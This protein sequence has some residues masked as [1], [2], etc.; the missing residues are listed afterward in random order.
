M[1]VTLLWR[2]DVHL[3]DH[4]PRSRKDDWTAT[5][6]SKLAQIG[7]LARTH[8]AAAVL[9]GGDFF[10]LK[11]PTRNSHALIQQVLAVH[12]GYPC[13]VYANVGNHDCVYG[14]YSFL[15]QQP[16]GVLYESGAFRRCY[17]EHEAVFTSGGVTVR[18][19][20]VP[21]HGTK[22]DLDRFAR[23]KKGSEN[24]LVVMAHV[25][26]SPTGG[27]LFESED[28]IKYAD[29]DQFEGDAFCFLPGT[30]LVDWN[31]RQIDVEA[32]SQSLAL[33]GRTG[34]VVVE[35][36]HPVR[37]IDEDVIV[38]DVEGIPSSLIPGVT[39]EH[40]FWVARGLRCNLPSRASRRCHPDKPRESYP[41]RLCHEPPDV[42]PDWVAAGQIVA[43]DYMAIPVRAIP[44]GESVWEPG[45][46]RLLGYYLAEGHAI[47]NRK[48]DPVAGIGWSFHSEEIDLHDDVGRLVSEYFGLVTHPCFHERY[49]NHS[50]QIRA[51]GPELADF[52]VQHGGRYAGGKVLSSTV[53]GLSAGARL[54]L[55]VGWLLGDGHAR[56]PQKYD[57][58]KV[59]VMGATVSPNLAS[60]LHA[61]AL[62]IGLRPFY[63][64]RPAHQ[65]TWENGHVSDC[66]PCHVLSFYGNDAEMLGARIGVTFPDRTK[67]KVAGF[68]RDGMYWAR[69]RGVSSIPY[70]GPVYNIRTHTQEYV[71][72]LLL[73]HN[74]FGHWHKDQGISQTS[75]GKTIINTG[76]LTRGSLSQDDLDR[77]PSVVRLDFSEGGVV[78]TQVP[79]L[80]AAS[81]EVFDLAT[82]D[83]V[84]LRSSMMEDFVGHLQAV[85]S[86][87]TRGSL[88]DA[89]RAF[90]GIPDEVKEQAVFYVEKAG[91]R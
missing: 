50:T 34:P 38:L 8:G 74:C 9:D 41:C 42:R 66:L 83:Q 58:V 35:E 70:Q 67:T 51:F 59:E 18:V 29:L 62:S 28:V 21:Y 10:D 24:Y 11:S 32:V 78:V 82:R 6:I 64:I 48:G 3:S 17:D 16:L 40:P 30:K 14:D 56:D 26:A 77:K 86:P 75:G 37:Q 1:T 45:L 89:I 69:V 80:A 84:E 19:V 90:P 20:G 71:A 15:P 60:Q 25:L 5:V 91:G 81:S 33:D 61:L 31:G 12:R 54:E 73:T 76:S 47:L 49:G 72:G 63:S 27:M 57:R 52:M 22:Y 79:L 2:T 88:R 55:L 23:I 13:P 36:V 87:A 43:G 44:Q 85:L 68:F 39:S 7:E 53:W 65:F 4:T 46:A